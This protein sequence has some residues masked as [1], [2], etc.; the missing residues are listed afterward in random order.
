MNTD[1]IREPIESHFCDKLCNDTYMAIKYKFPN[2]ENLE[3][4]MDDEGSVNV[5]FDET[6]YTVKQVQD[7]LDEFKKKKITIP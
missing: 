5:I 7:F 2:I 3:V 1:N 6:E 4:G